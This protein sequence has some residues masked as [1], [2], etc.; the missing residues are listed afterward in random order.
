MLASKG[1][2]GACT[3]WPEYHRARSGTTV[4]G[5]VSRPISVSALSGVVKVVRSERVV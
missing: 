1:V 5:I 3:H 4:S 2:G